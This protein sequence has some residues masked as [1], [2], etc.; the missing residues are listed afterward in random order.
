MKKGGKKSCIR[1]RE[2]SQIKKRRRWFAYVIE[3]G[4]LLKS[5]E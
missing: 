3:P 1:L 5:P 2:M 4:V